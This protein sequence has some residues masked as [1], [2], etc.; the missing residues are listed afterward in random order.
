MI[1]HNPQHDNT[2][3]S[4]LCLHQRL[5]GG[6]A[7][8]CSGNTVSL[9]PDNVGQARR[10]TEN[11]ANIAL[12]YYQQ[13]F[14][15]LQSVMPTF[16]RRLHVWLLDAES[17]DPSLFVSGLLGIRQEQFTKQKAE[18]LDSK[19]RPQVTRSQPSRTYRFVL[20]TT[21][22]VWGCPE[23]F[24]CE[25]DTTEGDRE[26][27]VLDGILGGFDHCELTDVDHVDEDCVGVTANL[28]HGFTMDLPF[29]PAMACSETQLGY[30]LGKAEQ[31]VGQESCGDLYCLGLDDM[32]VWLVDE[33]GQPKEYVSG[34]MRAKEGSH[35]A[36]EMKKWSRRSLENMPL[37]LRSRAA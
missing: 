26:H 33:S 8:R 14:M 4:R 12:S 6:L 15:A 20:N 7:R 13:V 27:A 32:D 17:G 9:E 34:W 10:L 36:A 28:W 35:T 21:A 1:S 5:V 22:H 31:L 30:L 19:I 37:P 11:P 16:H 23:E 2:L 18:R 24:E 3:R 25:E 29:K